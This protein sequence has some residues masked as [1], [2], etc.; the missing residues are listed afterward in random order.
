VIDWISIKN[1]LARLTVEKDALHI[2]AAL[3]VQLAAAFLLRKPLG[4][5]LPW[6]AVLAAAVANEAG[7]FLLDETESSIQ[8][9]QIDGSIHDLVNTMLLPTLLLLLV[10][11]RPALF[12]PP[13]A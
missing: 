9:W 2:Y 10:R 5:W 6:L 12:Q 11:Y 4:S 13:P 8:Q 7:D 3:V 1:E